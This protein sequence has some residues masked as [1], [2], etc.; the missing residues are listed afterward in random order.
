MTETFV[1][2]LLPGLLLRK[3]HKQAKPAEKSLAIDTAF[4]QK[5]SRNHQFQKASENIPETK[6]RC[7]EHKEEVSFMCSTCTVLV[8][9]SCVTGNHN[10][11]TFSK[12]V[13]VIA[14]LRVENETQIHVKTNEANQNMKQIEDNLK[15]FEY[16]VDSVIN[17]IIKRK[18]KIKRMI[19]KSV[20]EMITLV[21]N[22]SKKQKEK[23]ML[24]LSDS[25]SLLV[26]GQTI[27]K[28]DRN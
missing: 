25:K 19:D 14:K 21:K 3:I 11:H 9:A 1:T 28:R 12:L 22:Q 15:S 6:S 27:E 18:D 4:L 23:L 24:M 8:C 2:Y 20:A 13:D 17:A 16:G 26:A 7:S 5:L 10:G